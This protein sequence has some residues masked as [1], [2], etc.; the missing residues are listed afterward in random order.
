MEEHVEVI[1][2]V[3][4]RKPP[5]RKVVDGVLYVGGGRVEPWQLTEEEL[6]EFFPERYRE[7]YGGIYRVCPYPNCNGQVNDGDKRTYMSHFRAVHEPFYELHRNDLLKL[8]DAAGVDAY[9]RKVTAN[10]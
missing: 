10:V 8:T 3:I 9:V 1:P 2:E 7:V 5:V 6:M 4:D